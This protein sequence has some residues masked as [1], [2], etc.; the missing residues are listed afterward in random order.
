MKAL[1]RSSGRA[2]IFLCWERLYEPLVY[3]RYAGENFIAP[4][5]QRKNGKSG[6]GN[7]EDGGKKPRG[8]EA[9]SIGQAEGVDKV[10]AEAGL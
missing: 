10:N 2:F 8:Y 1:P 5:A 3:P 7:G 9:L 6:E 4:K